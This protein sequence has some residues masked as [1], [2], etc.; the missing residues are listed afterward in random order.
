M[1][2]ATDST[3]HNRIPATKLSTYHLLL[4]AGDSV[5]HRHHVKC[6]RKMIYMEV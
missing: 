2:V 6:Q 5:E 3:V 4:E 1:S